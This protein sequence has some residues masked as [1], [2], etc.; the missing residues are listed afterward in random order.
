MNIISDIASST[1]STSSSM[2]S[3]SAAST[4]SSSA[5]ATTA[6]VAESSKPIISIEGKVL[7]AL[8]DAADAFIQK[9]HLVPFQGYRF[10][11]GSH[12][13]VIDYEGAYLDVGKYNNYLFDKAAA[14]LVAE[15]RNKGIEL[16]KK[17]VVAQLKENNAE[18][19][20]MKLDDQNRRD[21]LGSTSVMSR[22]GWS[23]LQA[24]TDMY[25]TAKENGLDVMQVEVLANQKGTFLAP[26][27]TWGR[28]DPPPSGVFSEST[29]GLAEEIR[30][31]LTDFFGIGKET[32]DFILDPQSGFF[33]V[34]G[35]GTNFD[36]ATRARLDFL[37][38][39]LD[40]QD[41]GLYYSSQNQEKFLNHV[42]SQ[43]KENTDTPQK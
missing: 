40:L 33:G 3:K 36:V 21:L 26:G 5:S 38:K 7:S 1:V 9:E 18:I 27:V 29:F 15:A 25:I 31:R 30:G 4:V 39:L 6:A 41:A 22:L 2:E 17:D 42:L 13:Y 32:F 37:T 35:D 43:S 24:F 28:I 14:N 20:A 10:T 19:A 11:N 12:G 34:H 8:F 23:D 16:D